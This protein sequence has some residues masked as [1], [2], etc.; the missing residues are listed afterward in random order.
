LLVYEQSS[1]DFFSL[2]LLF[3][4]FI[5]LWVPLFHF[6]LE[7]LSPLKIGQVPLS[8]TCFSSY[9]LEEISSF[10]KFLMIIF[11]ISFHICYNKMHNKVLTALLGCEL[12]QGRS[13]VTNILCVFQ[14][15]D[16]PLHIESVHKCLWNNALK[17]TSKESCY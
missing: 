16:S 9:L 17:C 13:Q 2:C 15:P 7:S 8:P 10:Y 3:I 6:C 5:S 12:L 4:W 11:H 14:F 1:V